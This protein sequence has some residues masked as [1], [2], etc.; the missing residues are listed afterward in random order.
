[1]KIKK[2]ITK[3]FE[4]DDSEKEI[5]NDFLTIVDNMSKKCVCIIGCSECPFDSM[6]RSE[7]TNADMIEEI[8]DKC[9]TKDVDYVEE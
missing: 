5:I 3:K 1:M 6:C 9:F 2:V 4:F 7:F 8:F